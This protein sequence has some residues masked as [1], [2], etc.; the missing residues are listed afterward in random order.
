MKPQEKFI[1]SDY[2]LKEL[3]QWLNEFN[4]ENGKN[5]FQKVGKHYFLFQNF[6]KIT[7]DNVAWK[8]F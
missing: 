3:P 2:Y 7:E 5:W 4:K 8:V 6:Q 1:T